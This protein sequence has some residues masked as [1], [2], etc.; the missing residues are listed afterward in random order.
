MSIHLD[1]M[2]VIS[3]FCYSVLTVA[4]FQGYV[5]GFSTV[6]TRAGPIPSAS[7]LYSSRLA[8]PLDL[9]QYEHV[10]PEITEENPLRILI[11][12]AGVGGLALA[13]SLSKNPRMKVSVPT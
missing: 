5:Q 6:S 3:R 4:L 8:S 2:N 11:A 1:I 12:G 13:N 10:E 9:P 7:L